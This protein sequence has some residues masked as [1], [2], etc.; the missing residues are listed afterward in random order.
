MQKIKTYLILLVIAIIL[1]MTTLYQVEI[2]GQS[3]NTILT[4]IIVAIT[5]FS[6]MLSAK[7]YF[8]KIKIDEM[9]AFKLIIPII[10]I[11]FVMAMPIFRSH[12]EDAHW[13]RI[14]DISL[15]NFFT[16]TEYGH[17]FQEGATNYPA[18]KLPRAVSTVLDKAYDGSSTKEI[19]DVK[20]DE[21]DEVIY[22][23]PTT[24]IYSP[25]QYLPQALG[26]FI[27]RMF[28]D[29]PIIMAYAARFMNVI[30]SFTALY[31][32]IK[33]MPFGKKIL[34]VAM[35]IPIALE[36][37]TSLSPDG[38]T[39]S[40]SFLFI[41]YILNLCFKKKNERFTWKQGITVTILGVIL[42]LCK[43]VYLPLVGLVL[44]LPKTKFTSR[45]KQ[46]ITIA[47]IMCVAII[48]NLMWLSYSTNYLAEYEEGRP[49]D[50]L[51]KL[52]SNPIKY[53]ETVIYSIDLN[54]A[55]YFLSMFGGEVRTK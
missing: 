53:L 10:T 45:K 38:M 40:F 34:L 52:L 54:G 1:L 14:Y 29:R 8:E 11:L 31:F 35:S 36:G 15:G 50:Q 55:K 13:L 23:L 33:L 5:F 21:D 24:A 51:T 37:F 22:A 26:V 17:L 43:I 44:I 42:A 18:A 2:K 41:A 6:V 12:D 39:I 3:R 16:S 19:F 25:T 48:A 46:A 7:I 9:F 30:V 49:V 20:I 32:A 47:I 28:T 27:A 4:F